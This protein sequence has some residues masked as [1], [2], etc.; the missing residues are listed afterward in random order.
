MGMNDPKPW[1]LRIT[2]ETSAR[3]R[4]EELAKTDLRS[5]ANYIRTL[6]EKDARER[7]TPQ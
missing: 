7:E 4:V 5:P 2:L 3:E 1:H 6:I